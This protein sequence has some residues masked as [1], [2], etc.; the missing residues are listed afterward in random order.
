MQ[1]QNLNTMRERQDYSPIV[2]KR[3]SRSKQSHRIFHLSWSHLIRFQQHRWYLQWS[4]H[5]V[6]MGPWGMLPANL[7]LMTLPHELPGN[8]DQSPTTK[9][10]VSTYYLHIYVVH[11]NLNTQQLK[12]RETVHTQYDKSRRPLSSAIPLD[13]LGVLRPS[14]HP[15]ACPR[16]SWSST[17]HNEISPKQ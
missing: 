15:R 12:S 2:R 13:V 7:R 4:Q 3:H 5:L 8:D 1:I 6:E 11:S 9:R 16:I 10:N 14:T 17:C